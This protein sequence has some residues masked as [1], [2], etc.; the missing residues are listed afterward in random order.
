MSPHVVGHPHY[1]EFHIGK[2]IS[3]GIEIPPSAS[4]LVA[5]VIGVDCHVPLRLGPSVLAYLF[6]L[7]RPCYIGTNPPFDLLHCHRPPCPF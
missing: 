2:L 1:F 3:H 6:A 7:Y 4:T 5:L